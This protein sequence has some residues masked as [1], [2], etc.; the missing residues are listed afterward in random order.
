MCSSES[1]PRISYVDVL[2]GQYDTETI[3]GKRVIVGATAIELGDQIAVP[4]AAARA[5]KQGMKVDIAAID[6]SA[7]GPAIQGIVDVI[8]P[9]PGTNGVDRHHVYLRVSVVESATIPPEGAL[10][11]LTIRIGR[12]D[13]KSSHMPSKQSPVSPKPHRAPGASPDIASSRQRN[14][15]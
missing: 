12:S 5:L 4:V 3:R 13:E 6:A 10:L 7:P 15:R 2:T 14:P 9:R 1:I 11:R 8:A